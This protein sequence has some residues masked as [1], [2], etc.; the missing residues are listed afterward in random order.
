MANIPILKTGP[1][2]GKANCSKI[3]T[4]DTCNLPKYRLNCEPVMDGNKFM[5][6]T[7]KK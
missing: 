6:C 7:F 1:N 5:K 3:K 2:K 4:L